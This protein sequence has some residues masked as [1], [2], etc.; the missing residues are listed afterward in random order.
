MTDRFK[1]ALNIFNRALGAF[2]L[3][4]NTRMDMII[5]IEDDVRES[6]TLATEAEQLRKERDDY[7]AKLDKAK[8]QPIDKSRYGFECILLSETRKISIGQPRN[9]C[10]ASLKACYTH[11]IDLPDV[12]E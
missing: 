8:W 6:L 7:K 10:D 4:A 2:G 12:P 1:D 3:R 5:K 9:F 11:F